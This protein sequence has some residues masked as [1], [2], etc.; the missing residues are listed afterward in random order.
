MISVGVL[1]PADFYVLKRKISIKNLHILKVN[2]IFANV[3]DK[4]IID[5][6]R[7]IAEKTASKIT[8]DDKSFVKTL[9]FE[10]GIELPKDKPNCKSCY[11][12]AAVMIYKA[13]RESEQQVKA[14]ANARKYVL[15]EGVDVIW[16]GVR[17]NEASV[18]DEL[19][20]QWIAGGFPASYF[21]KK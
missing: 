9:A 15:R 7:E 6:L 16:R 8:N 2:T 13:I 21:V 5:K 19:A 14:K 4:N 12:D 20:E 3:M 1:L 10:Y 17:I 18:T 11:V